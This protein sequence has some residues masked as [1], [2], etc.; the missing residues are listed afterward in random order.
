MLKSFLLKIWNSDIR[1]LQLSLMGILLLTGV[2]IQDFSI[3][4]KQVVLTFISGF[5]TQYFWIKWNKLNKNSIFSGLI[6]CL[7]LSLLLRSDTYW[8][9][10]IIAFLTISSKFLIKYKKKHIFNPA[11]LGVVLGI[12]IFPGTWIS[13]GQ[14]G[15]EIIIIF[16]LLLFGLLVSRRARIHD[17]SFAFLFFYIGMVYI[18]IFYFGY[19]F[20]VFIHQISNGALILFSFFMITDPR[21]APNHR[22]GRIFHAFFVALFTF[23][24]QFYYFKQSGLIWALF[25]LSPL[26][27]FWDVLFKAKIFQ[28]NQLL[29][30]NFNETKQNLNTTDNI[31]LSPTSL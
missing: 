1:I 29:Q 30:G 10:P 16:F 19:E 4:Y 12:S 24:W 21:T 27:P 28:W 8:V 11:M 22:K 5:I 9:H 25:F 6:T 18:R 31:N 13:P 14:W 20:S 3:S 15:D 23:I 7:G 26:V 2:M 17:I